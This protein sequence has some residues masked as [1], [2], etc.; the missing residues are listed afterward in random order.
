MSPAISILDVAREILPELPK[1]LGEDAA[2]VRQELTNLLA[3]AHSG[4]AV[5]HE[6][7]VVLGKNPATDRWKRD[8][9]REND[10]DGG[11]EKSYQP[12]PGLRSTPRAVKYACPVSGCN[13]PPWFPIDAGDEIPSCEIHGV[14]FE[15][16]SDD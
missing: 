9:L 1:L 10:A 12:L 3:R 11:D 14:P 7:R 5:D 4:K 13:T 16:V 15:A 8:R 6:I 2:A